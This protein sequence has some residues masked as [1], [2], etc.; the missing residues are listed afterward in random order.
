[1]GVGVGGEGRDDRQCEAISSVFKHG[2][3]S[4]E[5]MTSVPAMVLPEGEMPRGWEGGVWRVLMFWVGM[6]WKEGSIL[7]MNEYLIFPN[8][9]PTSNRSV[10]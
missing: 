10:R 9:R 3:P 4:P 6:A 5:R 2:L 8:D 1:M 7:V